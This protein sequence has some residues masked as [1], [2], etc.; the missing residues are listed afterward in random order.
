MTEGRNLEELR[1]PDLARL[2]SIRQRSI[3]EAT[4]TGRFARRKALSDS[5]GSPT[6]PRQG[7]E[8]RKTDLT[9]V[10]TPAPTTKL[11]T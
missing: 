5:P 8:S 10:G 6:G 7:E 2:L 1:G 3:R 4:G 9:D 11:S